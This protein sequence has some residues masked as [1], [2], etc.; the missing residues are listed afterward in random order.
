MMYI[1]RRIKK[2]HL[3]SVH[4]MSS[5]RSGEEDNCITDYFGK[6]KNNL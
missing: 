2:L 4:G 3:I 5:T 1:Y 6:L